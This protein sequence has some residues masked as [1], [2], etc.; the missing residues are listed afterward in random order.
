MVH[1]L[2][3]YQMNQKTEIK[4]GDIFYFQISKKYYFMQIINITRN[5]DAPYNVS[6][7]NFGIFIT[8]FEKAFRTLPTSIDELDLQTVYQ[9]KSKPKNS[10]LYICDWRE[11]LELKIDAN[12]ANFAKNT[13]IDVQYFAN[14]KITK[15]F[16]PELSQ[17]FDLP[18]ISMEDE[19]GVCISALPAKLNYIFDRIN[20]DDAKLSKKRSVVAIQYFAEWLD[21]VDLDVIIKIEKIFKLFEYELTTKDMRSALKKCVNSVN[22]LE[23]KKVFI[24]T[25]EVETLME[26]IFTVAI[27]HGMDEQNIKEIV[28]Q[29][30]DW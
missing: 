21:F 26:S 17:Q 6:A 20:D 30:R 16:I 2:R 29:N 9:I 15:H 3:M 27:K 12:T 13:N 25:F 10:L 11:H 14:T 4:Q 1:L 5:L 28:E 22:K 8:V 7:F 24:G 23:Q 19:N 18:I